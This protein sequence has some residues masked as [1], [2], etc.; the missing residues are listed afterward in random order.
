MTCLF[1]SNGLKVKISRVQRV[2]QKLE[3]MGLKGGWANF[4]I[5]FNS[6]IF[7]SKCNNLYLFKDLLCFCFV[8]GVCL[9]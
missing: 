8:F 5:L 4:K 1:F 3:S 7:D 9:C 6:L 2:V